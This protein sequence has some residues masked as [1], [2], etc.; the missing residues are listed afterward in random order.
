MFI[1]ICF[2]TERV[3]R[4]QRILVMSDG[5]FFFKFFLLRGRMLVVNALN[6]KG[7]T[8]APSCNSNPQ[9][10]PRD[11]NSREETTEPS[12]K[13]LQ[14]EFFMHYL[15]ILE[16]FVSRQMGNHDLWPRHP[17]AEYGKISCALYQ[18]TLKFDSTRRCRGEM[19]SSITCQCSKTYH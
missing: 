19:Y 17:V 3:E 5:V 18:H 6:Y 12:P 11:S 7:S 2:V 9:P 1:V 16:V 13:V 4:A 8:A 14:M 10:H 15:F